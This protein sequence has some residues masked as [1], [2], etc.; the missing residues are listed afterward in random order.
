MIT[1]NAMPNQTVYSITIQ[2]GDSR[3]KLAASVERRTSRQRGV[4]AWGAIAY[5]SGSPLIGIG[6]IMTAQRYVDDVLRPVTL[7]SGVPNAIF[8]QDS[9]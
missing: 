6:G 1:H 8:Q 9:A 5:D 4:M 2:S 3:S 7:P